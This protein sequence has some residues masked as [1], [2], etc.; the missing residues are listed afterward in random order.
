MRNLAHRSA[1][2][3]RETAPLIEESI[4]IS[5]AGSVELERTSMA[6]H[7][8]ATSSSRARKLVDEVNLGSED[9]AQGMG[10]VSLALVQMQDTIQNSAASSEETAAAS[11][12]MASQAAVMNN[13]ARQLR[14]VV[15]G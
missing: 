2:A 1:Q 9:Q 5:N 8:I 7:A 4:N 15:Q 6:I 13:I 3:A 11:Q 14:V 12:E 10:L